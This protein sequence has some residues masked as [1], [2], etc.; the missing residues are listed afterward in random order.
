M[1]DLELWD[2]HGP[3]GQTF[4]SLL[5]VLTSLPARARSA[6][7]EVA[8]FVNPDG[9]D[10]FEVG[11]GGDERVRA[12]ANTGQRVSGSELLLLAEGSSQ[13]IWG[14]FRGY[15]ADDPTPW[16]RLHAIDSTFWRCETRDIATRQALM[17]AFSDVRLAEQ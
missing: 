10:W 4:L 1:K 14:T 8:D 9:V 6:N 11:Y 15:D 7:W 16:I 2:L 3:N 5:E 13:I 12:L 17:K